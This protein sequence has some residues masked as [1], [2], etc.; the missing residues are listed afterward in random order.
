MSLLIQLK[1]TGKLSGDEK[2]IGKISFTD[3]AAASFVLFLAGFETS[4]SALSYTLY[5]LALH[6][7]IQDKTR[8][9]INKVLEEHN[10]EVTYEAINSMDYVGQ[11]INEAMR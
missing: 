11:V 2:I 5:E 1:N 10:G 9:E 6:P 8:R 4:S 3:L 7:E